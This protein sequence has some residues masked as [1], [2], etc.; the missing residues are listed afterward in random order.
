MPLYVAGS[1]CAS[2]GA[3]YLRDWANRPSEPLFSAAWQ[4]QQARRVC[5]HSAESPAIFGGN[6]N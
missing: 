3:K 5:S 6:S 1:G 2:W 4:K